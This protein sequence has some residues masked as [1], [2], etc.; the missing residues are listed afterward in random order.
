MEEPINSDPLNEESPA[1]QSDLSRNIVLVGISGS[2]KST[3]G[4][5]LA[6]LLGFGFLDLDVIVERT[7]GR[8]IGRIFQDEGEAV[9]RAREVKALESVANIK[10]HVVALGGGTLGNEDA[11]KAARNIGPLVWLKPS[12]DEVARRLYMRPDELNKRPL[13]KQFAAIEDKE[14]RRKAI[15]ESIEAM[16]SGRSLMY[17]TADIVLDGGFVTPET[18]ACQLK[19]IL[20]SMGLVSSAPRRHQFWQS[21]YL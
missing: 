12:P 21:C 20:S 7:A 4:R 2:G 10:S 13:L 1:V 6:I 15:R 5:H 11:L 16:N 9:F 19:D 18:S 3:V 8:S 17:Q 14:E